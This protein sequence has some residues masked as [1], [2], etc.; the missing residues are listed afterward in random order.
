MLVGGLDIELGQLTKTGMNIAVDLS[1]R[2]A[3]F[4]GYFMLCCTAD[5]KLKHIVPTSF[6][7][8]CSCLIPSDIIL[9]WQG[10][11]WVLVIF[12]LPLQS[13]DRS[14]Q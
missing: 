1:L 11:S 7:Y 8:L 5:Y 13:L 6:R 4:S 3:Y 10:N 12:P 2:H 14:H 9:S